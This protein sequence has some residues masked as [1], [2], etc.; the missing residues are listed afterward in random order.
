VCNPGCHS[1]GTPTLVFEKGSLT[2]GTR[3]C[4]LVPRGELV[5]TGVPAIDVSPVLT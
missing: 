4:P 3:I 2:L 1:L 5:S